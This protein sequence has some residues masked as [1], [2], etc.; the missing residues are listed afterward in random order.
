MNVRSEVCWLRTGPSDST[1]TSASNIVFGLS[2]SATILF[3]KLFSDR[4]HNAESC[5]SRKYLT[6][7]LTYSHK[8]KGC[9]A[10]HTIAVTR[11]ARQDVFLQ[12]LLSVTDTCTTT[13]SFKN[14]HSTGEND[15]KVLYHAKKFDMKTN[16]W[17]PYR[18]KFTVCSEIQ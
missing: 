13:Y 9:K 2:V 10:T 16:Q 11:L 15:A 5:V 7:L 8:Q 18:T 17:M 3:R 6:A 12:A 14:F 4:L 1:Q